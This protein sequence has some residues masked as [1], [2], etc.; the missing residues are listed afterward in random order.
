MFL[1]EQGGEYI[2]KDILDLNNKGI[3][4][5]LY[6]NSDKFPWF[7]V[8]YNSL[9][10]GMTFFGWNT[11]EF[12]QDI[13]IIINNKDIKIKKISPKSWTIMNVGNFNEVNHVIIMVDGNIKN[14][15]DFNIIDKEV[16]KKRNFLR[17]K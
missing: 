1:I 7:I 11:T 8:I 17:N 14:V 12:Q 9:I 13:K 6:V 16:F 3:N 10:N 4:V 5:G 2:Y 15:L